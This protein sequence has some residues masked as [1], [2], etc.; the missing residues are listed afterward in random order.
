MRAESVDLQTRYVRASA[1]VHNEL[2]GEVTMMNVETGKYYG[3]V[4]PVA[5]HIWRL[6]ETPVSGDE[7]CQQLIQQYRVDRSRCETEVLTFLRRM[8]AEEVIVAATSFTAN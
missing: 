7:I 6:L 3:L 5:A 2:D 8:A 4:S 1:L